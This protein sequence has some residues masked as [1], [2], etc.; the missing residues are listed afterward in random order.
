MKGNTS[1]LSRFARQ[2]ALNTYR[3]HT[4]IVGIR[5]TRHNPLGID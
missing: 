4:S 2:L 1:R 3:R 5:E